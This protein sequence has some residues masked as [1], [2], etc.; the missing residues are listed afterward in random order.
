MLSCC[1]K[2]WRNLKCILLSERSQPEKKSNGMK[3][4]KEN[5]KLSFRSSGCGTA[6][7]NPARIH[8]DAGLIP[9]LAQWVK[10]PAL[11]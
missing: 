3:I 6:E 8:E 9:G 4:G 11:P 1:E 5:I 10:D 7:T 2:T